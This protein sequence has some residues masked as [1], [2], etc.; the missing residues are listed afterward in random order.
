MDSW[1][2][3]VSII[4]TNESISNEEKAKLAK[5]ENYSIP[6]VTK[7]RPMKSQRNI[8]ELQFLCKSKATGLDNISAKLLREWPDR[9]SNSLTTIFNKFIQKGVFPDK[10]KNARVTPLYKI[11]YNTIQS[12]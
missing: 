3:Y 8:K 12:L 10:W 7:S 11:Q 1:C 2:G 5:V 6:L 4:G 9:I